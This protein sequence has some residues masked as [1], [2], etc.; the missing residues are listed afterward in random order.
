MAPTAARGTSWARRLMRP[1]TSIATHL[2]AAP[3]RQP[4]R[5]D[6][7]RGIAGGQRRGRF[8]M[9]DVEPT[10]ELLVARHERGVFACVRLSACRNLS[11]VAVMRSAPHRRSAVPSHY[12]RT[13]SLPKLNIPSSSIS[14]KPQ[15]Y[16]SFFDV[17][18][19]LLLL[20]LFSLSL[21]W[22]TSP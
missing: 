20:K 19:A 13:F 11:G 18:T 9:G 10:R 12:L 15:N 5:G 16:P 17:V 8:G 1:A 21:P 22:R 2:V 7:E 6:A 14:S 4:P 3:G